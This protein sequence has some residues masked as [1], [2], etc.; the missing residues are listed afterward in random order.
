MNPET[1]TVRTADLLNLVWMARRYA[2]GRKTY[3][4]DLFNEAYRNTVEKNGLTESVDDSGTVSTYPL[5]NETLC[6]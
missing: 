6:P 4:P 3:A 1:V 2:H 5:A